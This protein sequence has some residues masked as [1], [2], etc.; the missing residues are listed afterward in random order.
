MPIEES[1]VPSEIPRVLRPEY[2]VDGDSPWQSYPTPEAA[3]EREAELNDTQ[4]KNG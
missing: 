2:R 4:S 1:F 3:K